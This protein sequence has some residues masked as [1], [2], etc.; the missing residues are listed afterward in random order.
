MESKC[1]VPIVKYK[2]RTNKKAFAECLFQ[3][4][5]V[6]NFTSIMLKQTAKIQIQIN[7]L[8]GTTE[9]QDL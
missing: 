5:K 2:V 9:N 1:S 6:I 8:N 7:F 4:C 3:A